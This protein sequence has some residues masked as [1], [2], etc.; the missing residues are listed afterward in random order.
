M[1]QLIATLLLATSL[2]AQTTSTEISGTVADSTGAVIPNARVTLHRLATGEHRTATTSNTGAY[3][4][5]LI[6]IGDY[7]V[8][9]EMAG[10]QRQEKTGI[11]LQLQQ[12]LRIDFTLNV[13]ETSEK[14]EVVSSA[15]QLKTEDASVGQVI[16]NKRVVELPLNGRNI[17]TFASGSRSDAEIVEMMI[18]R[19]YSH[20][21]PPKPAGVPQ[22]PPVLEARGLA[23]T[24]RLKDIALQVRPGEV[25]GLGGLD[26]QGQREL[27]LALFGVLRGV[28]GEILI[29]G[30]PARITGPRAARSERV[31]MALIPED[32]KTEGLMLPMSVRDNLS[33]AALSRFAAA[34][35][36]LRFLANGYEAEGG[37]SVAAETQVTV[38]PMEYLVGWK[39]DGDLHYVN[40]GAERS[41]QLIA[42]GP[43]AT[44]VAANG[45]RALVLERK[46][47]SVLT[48]QWNGTYKYV[49]VKKELPMRSDSCAAS[50]SEL[51]AKKA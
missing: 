35:Y 12:K 6:E 49:S 32:R 3:S 11:R 30:R 17:A 10:F 18:G 50:F 9:A 5:P 14:I 46:Y 31:R 48:K 39:P 45:L 29:H 1:S 27:L 43:Q 26:G 19:S 13:G 33:F 51:L 36:R 21:F 15:V 42:V 40:K 8:S 28:K 7:T 38:S 44:R 16:D 47:L 20:V 37:R 24:D 23:W 41:V 4:F 22:A 25:V 34:T 2:Y